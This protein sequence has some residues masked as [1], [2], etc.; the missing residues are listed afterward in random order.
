MLHTSE[1]RREY[2]REWRQKNPDLMGQIKLRK[3]IKRH[4]LALFKKHEYSGL[5]RKCGHPK[6]PEN[7][8]SSPSRP[9]G[10]CRTCWDKYR[11]T[12]WRAVNLKYLYGISETEYDA[13]VIAQGGVC[14][15]CE[16]PP[17]PG[18]RLWVDHSHETG[19]V[20]AL[21][22]AACNTTLGLVQED[23]ERLSALQAYL[24]KH[25]PREF[26]IG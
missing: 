2:Q 1:G 22:C 24:G 7:T 21:L 17:T 9:T 10:Q 15:I 14:A 18:K 6:S 20:R 3:E 26:S 8:M 13:R 19:V 11:A 25:H 16:R 12:K 5:W 4:A 23:F